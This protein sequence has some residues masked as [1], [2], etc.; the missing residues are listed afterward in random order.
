MLHASI[1]KKIRVF[2]TSKSLLHRTNFYGYKIDL[3]KK[4]IIFYVKKNL[5]KYNTYKHN[6]KTVDFLKKKFKFFFCKMLVIHF[7]TIILWLLGP[8]H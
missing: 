5:K 1:T 2:F 7:I 8:H 6:D 4:R 3:L